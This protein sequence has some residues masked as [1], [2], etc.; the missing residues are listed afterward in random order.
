MAENKLPIFFRFRIG[1]HILF[2]VVIFLM[3]WLSYGGYFDNY[4]PE[5]LTGL[6]VLP[7]RIIG[8]YAFIYLVLPFATE[9]KQFLI[10]G[11]LIV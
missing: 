7:A 4:Y 11:F 9:K 10:F 5:F 8:T 6:T 1:W 3:Y 2:W